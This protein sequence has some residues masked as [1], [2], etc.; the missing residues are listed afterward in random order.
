LRETCATFH[1]ASDWATKR[2]TSPGSNPEWKVQK[3]I[4][5]R[6]CQGWGII[7]EYFNFRS[8]MSK[9]GEKIAF[10]VEFLLPCLPQ[11][12]LA[13]KKKQLYEVNLGKR[14]PQNHF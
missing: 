5:N 14:G 1:A 9:S 3:S 12:N 7:S 2:G 10:S 13:T 6:G 8:G 4:F 11:D